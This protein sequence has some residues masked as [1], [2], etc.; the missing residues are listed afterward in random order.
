MLTPTFTEDSSQWQFSMLLAEQV[1]S[2]KSSAEAKAKG[3]AEPTGTFT[4]VVLLVGITGVGTGIT[5]D[6]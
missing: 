4:R 5:F 6:A 2:A 1:S 3:L